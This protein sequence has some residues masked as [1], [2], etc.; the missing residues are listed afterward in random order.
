MATD[1]WFKDR[2]TTY[3]LLFIRNYKGG[4][5]LIKNKLVRKPSSVSEQNNLS[6]IEKPLHHPV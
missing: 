5:A 2:I 3:F 1:F 6:R 4:I